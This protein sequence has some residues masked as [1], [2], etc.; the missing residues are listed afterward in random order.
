[1]CTIILQIIDINTK[2]ALGPLKKGEILIK[3]PALM[4]GYLTE[5]GKPVS[6]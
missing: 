1:V 2:E 3:G 6:I 4:A 5:Y